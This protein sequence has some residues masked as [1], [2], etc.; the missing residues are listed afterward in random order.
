MI[1]RDREGEELEV[2]GCELR[3]QMSVSVVNMI[4]IAITIAITI[5]AFTQLDC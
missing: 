4:S 2:S 5:P 1:E 3:C